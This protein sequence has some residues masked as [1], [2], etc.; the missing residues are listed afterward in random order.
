MVAKSNKNKAINVNYHIDNNKNIFLVKISGHSLGEKKV[1]SGEDLVC[2][3]VSSVVFGILNSL[4]EKLNNISIINS[5]KS[6]ENEITINNHFGD[7]KSSIILETLITSLE[8]IK[9]NY[10]NDILI[11]KNEVQNV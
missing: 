3:M 8:T 4:D 2:A 6:D 5:D 1:L 11:N 7:F 10:P 9:F